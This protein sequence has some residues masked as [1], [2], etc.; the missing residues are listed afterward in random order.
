MINER[1]GK[2][3]EELMFVVTQIAECAMIN[4]IK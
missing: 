2:R 3:R 4:K 1:W